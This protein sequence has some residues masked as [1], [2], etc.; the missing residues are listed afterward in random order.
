MDRLI[1]RLEAIHRDDRCKLCG[2]DIKTRGEAICIPCFSKLVEEAEN[3][4]SRT[5]H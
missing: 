1:D 3:E 4:S 2:K 5:T